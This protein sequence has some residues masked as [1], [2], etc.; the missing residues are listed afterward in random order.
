MKNKILNKCITFLQKYNN[1]S[2]KDLLKLQY[3]LEGIYLT[4]TK[5][6]IILLLAF[7]LGIFKEVILV[8]IFFNIIRFFGFG[9]HAEKSS[10]CLIM[11]IINFVLLPLLLLRVPTS[12]GV[13]LIISIF[14]IINFILFAPAD[15]IKRPLFSK[16]KRI[17]RKILT[18]TV[19][20]IYTVILSI[21]NTNYISS[22]LLSSLLIQVIM[23]NPLTY[24]IAGQ[25]YNNYKNVNKA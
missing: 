4:L 5:T 2:E 10:E 17:K 6:I 11:S 25:P 15:T 8:I 12:L 18:T 9:F 14:C 1:Y 20:I 13:D 21:F 16:S 22:I 19:G 23:V 24:L 3:G 7:I